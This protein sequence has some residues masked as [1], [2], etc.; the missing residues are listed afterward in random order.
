MEEEDD[1]PAAILSKSSQTERKWAPVILLGPVLPAIFAVV[2][3]VVGRFI[4]K[5]DEIDISGDIICGYPI[6]S[7][8]IA[9]IINSYLLLA[10]FAWTFL[11]FE[12]HFTIRGRKWLFL[13]PFS[14][15]ATVGLLYLLVFAVSIGVWILGTW[16]VA[17]DVAGQGCRNNNPVLYSFSVCLVTIYWIGVFF[18]SV[19]VIRTTCAQRI[20]S[21]AQAQLEKAKQYGQDR[22]AAELA[23]AEEQLVMRKFDDFDEK[24]EGFIDRDQFE[25]LVKDVAMN[26]S[27]KKLK[28]ALS[29]LD[30]EGKGMVEREAFL[31]W[32]RESNPSG[33]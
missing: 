14:S 32:Y 10:I 33:G 8:V 2:I 18:G 1:S 23:K 19:G 6:D 3:I 26:L 13:R 25:K 31:I 12:T 21:S 22:E 17:M 9:A 28:K 4:L 27:S 29:T 30:P 15:L 5:V 11:G 20:V 7:F 24:G 16:A